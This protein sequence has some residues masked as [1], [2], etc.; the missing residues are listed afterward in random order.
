MEMSATRDSTLANPEQRIAD[1]ER[2]LAERT[3]ERDEALQRETASTEVLQVINSS[4]GDLAPV[5][6]VMLEKATALCEAAFGTL[7]TYDGERFAPAAEYGVPIAFA[8]FRS[9]RGAF[10]P[11]PGSSLERVVNGENLVHIADATADPGQAAAPLVQ[12]GRCRSLVCVALRKD[13]R[14]VGAI[15]AYR[16]ELRPFSDK[17][18]ALLENFATQAVIA[19]ENARLITET[20]EALEQQTATAEVLQVIN[21][22]PGDLKPVFE[23]ILEKAAHLCEAPF[24][25]LRPWDGE[26]FHFG[27]VYGD[28]KFG[29]WLRQ[30]GPRPASAA[31][32]LGRIKAGERVLQIADAQNDAGFSTL[33]GLREFIEVSGI[34]STVIVALHRDDVLFGTIT[35]YRQEVRPFTDKQIGLLQNFAAQAVIA[36]ENARLITETREALEQQTATAEVLGV[37]NSSPGDLAPVFDAMLEKT[38]RL[39]EAVHGNFLTYDGEVFHQTAFRGEPQFAEY[40]RQ[41]GPLRPNRQLARAVQ[42]G[43]T[44]HR[45]DAREDE[46]YRD[47]PQFRQMVDGLGIRTSLAVPLRKGDALLGVVRAYRREVRPFTDKQI[48]LVESFAAQ[49]VIAMENARLLDELRQRTE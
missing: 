36:M 38:L 40:R 46:A 1:L 3:A 35:L 45:I 27:A 26:R 25:L 48:A 15:T 9:E 32:P 13:N 12:L 11:P 33:A 7:A 14:L 18:I 34:R 19:M 10:A 29:D 17:Q 49:A 39:C 28:A 30:L 44:V 21:S 23:A 16:Q 37:I 47:D 2:Q 5:F 43:G 6:D 22:S 42:G 4:P 8:T 20:R 24:G 41:Q 31:T